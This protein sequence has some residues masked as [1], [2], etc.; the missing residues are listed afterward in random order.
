[1]NILRL[2]F[3][4]IFFNTIF[5]QELE[6]SLLVV[7]TDPPFFPTFRKNSFDI[8]SLIGVYFRVILKLNN[9]F[10]FANHPEVIKEFPGQLVI[11]T[12]FSD[13]LVI[14]LGRSEV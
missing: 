10:S 12:S 1:M 5:T 2:L 14:F 9:P 6:K 13:H 11:F 4:Y 7:F 8:N 3:S